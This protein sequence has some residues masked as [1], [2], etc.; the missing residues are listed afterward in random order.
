M[1]H[2]G[3]DR[4]GVQGNTVVRNPVVTSEDHRA[5]GVDGGRGYLTLGASHPDR[6]IT[7]SSQSPGW[8]GQVSEALSGPATS[9]GRRRTN[10]RAHRI[11]GR[12]LQVAVSCDMNS[13][14]GR[15]ASRRQMVAKP[16]GLTSS[17]ADVTVAR[18]CQILTGFLGLGDHILGARLGWSTMGR[19][20]KITTDRRSR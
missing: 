12:L 2:G 4:L 3:G 1:H 9:V 16:S 14:G 7:E 19:A 10:V 13:P 20:Q 6:E 11:A 5:N 18:L 17:A 8:S 15:D